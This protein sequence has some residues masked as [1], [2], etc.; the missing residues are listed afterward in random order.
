MPWFFFRINIYNCKYLF[1]FLCLEN[2]GWK[3][4]VYTYFYYGAPYDCLIWYAIYI[5]ITRCRINGKQW[6]A[7]ALQACRD[8]K[9][10]Y[11]KSPK[12]YGVPCTNDCVK[13]KKNPTDMKNHL[14]RKQVLSKKREAFVTRH[15]LEME[16]KNFGET[17]K[18]VCRLAF[19]LCKEIWVL[20]ISRP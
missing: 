2:I 10:V 5:Y 13:M 8:H 19:R 12:L 17:K 16:K 6:K 15:C 7:K 9:M 18:D 11:K 3:K 1:K 14:G 20:H 4:V